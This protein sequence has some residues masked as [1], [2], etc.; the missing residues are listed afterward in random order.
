M[1][2][3]GAGCQ[4]RV[5][6]VAACRV[7]QDAHPTPLGCDRVPGAG[8]RVGVERVG[9]LEQ[10]GPACRL[11]A[12]NGVRSPLGTAPNDGDA[13]PGLRQGVGHRPAQ[14]ARPAEDDGGLTCK[15][16]KAAHAL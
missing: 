8:Q 4:G 12:A 14:H 9:R 7:D 10:S 5:G 6:A 2:E 13:R 3:I 11:D 1:S 16:E 15:I